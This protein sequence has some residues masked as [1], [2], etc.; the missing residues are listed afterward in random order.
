VPLIVAA[1]DGQRLEA[2]GSVMLFKATAATTGGR[3]S[4]M[5]RTLPPHGR[6]P[7][8]HRHPG[9]LEAFLV[10]EG[11]L[12]FHIEREPT[13][14]AAG[15]FVIVSEGEAH[16][17]V[18]DGDVPARVVILHSPP[19]DAYFEDLAALWVKGSTPS[20]EDEREVMQRHGL[21]PVNV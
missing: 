12:T 6:P 2:R 11:Q 20:P 15:G 7:A 18:N 9:T 14:V 13:P 8:A 4:L 3:F 5:D 1:G 19:L 16:T 21:E 10:L 17:F